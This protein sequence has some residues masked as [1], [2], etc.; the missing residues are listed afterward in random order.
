MQFPDVRQGVGVNRRAEVTGPKASLAG[1]DALDCS[2]EELPPYRPGGDWLEGRDLVERIRRIVETGRARDGTGSALTL[3][4]F[5]A[6][7]YVNPQ[8]G[9]TEVAE[10]GLEPG[11]A[12][13]PAPVSLSG[14][15]RAYQRTGYGWLKALAERRKW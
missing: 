6:P 8:T 14:E 4:A 13:W 9:E 5:T 10:T 2:F 7:F 11:I 3:L 1:T 12:A 15:L